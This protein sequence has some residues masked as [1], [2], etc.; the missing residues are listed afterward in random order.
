MIK[1]IHSLKMVVTVF[2]KKM[3]VV[4]IVPPFYFP[5]LMKIE[6]FK[7]LAIINNA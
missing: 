4:K 6:G 7:L 2:L 3:D 5:V 1:L